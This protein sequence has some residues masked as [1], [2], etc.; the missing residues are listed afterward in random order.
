MNNLKISLLER[1]VSKM[2]SILYGIEKVKNISNKDYKK[3]IK[4]LYDS[5]ETLQHIINSEKLL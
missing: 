2:D 5:K 3:L 4:Q 1:Y